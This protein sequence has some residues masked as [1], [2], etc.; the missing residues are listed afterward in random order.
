MERRRERE[1]QSTVRRGRGESI[2][3]FLDRGRGWLT[4]IKG[5]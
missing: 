3:L 1:G 2:D 4:E 5:K